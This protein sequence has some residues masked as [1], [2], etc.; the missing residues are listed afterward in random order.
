MGLPLLKLTSFSTFKIDRN[1]KGNE[2]S[3]NYWFLRGKLLVSG[4]VVFFQ[5]MVADPSVT[6]V[7]P[8]W[9]NPWTFQSCLKQYP[10]SATVVVGSTLALWLWKLYWRICIL[11]FMLIISNCFIYNR[12]LLIYTPIR[13]HVF[14]IQDQYPILQHLDI[15]NIYVPNLTDI[16]WF[17]YTM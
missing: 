17:M 12:F 5:R 11:T 10:T 15:F 3:S 9:A 16:S 2:A 4:R 8:C 14:Y 1:R 13:K 7:R 6:L